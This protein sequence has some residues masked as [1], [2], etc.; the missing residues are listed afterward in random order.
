VAP[1]GCAPPTR[2]GP[3]L[4]TTS[5]PSA[6]G[7]F[8]TTPLRSSQPSLAGSSPS[9]AAGRPNRAGRRSRSLRPSVP[10][11][12][13]IAR[14][15]WLLRRS[16][17]RS[18]GRDCRSSTKPAQS[19]AGGST[20]RSPLP[21]TTKSGSAPA[22]VSRRSYQTEAEVVLVP[23]DRPCAGSWAG[24]C[25]VAVPEAK[26][27]PRAMPRCLSAA[28]DSRLEDLIVAW[29]RGRWPPLRLLPARWIRPAVAPMALRLRRLLSRAV[30][31]AAPIGIILGLLILK[32]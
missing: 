15:G 28:I 10:L 2:N 17:G 4:V 8:H 13:A 25:I 5:S 22:A 31:T 6:Q 29:A 14:I 12:E 1:E 19:P 9:P 24:S 21:W 11:R 30:L 32:P 7:S 23:I 26:A 20:R 27:Y 18:P 3:R 16:T